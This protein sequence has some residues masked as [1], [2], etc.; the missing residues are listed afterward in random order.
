MAEK[1]TAVVFGSTGL[2]GEE[3]ISV[4]LANNDYEKVIAVTRKPLP[5][6]D[7]KL[8]EVQ[9]ADFSQLIQLGEKLK[10]S[11]FY[12]CIG[13]T[14][15]VAGSKEAFRKVDLDIPQEIAR[16]A[17]ALSIPALVVI[18][19]IG[20]SFESSNFYLKTKGEM[21]KSVR[22][23]YSGNLKIVRPS[24]LMG[25]RTEFRFGEKLGIGFMRIFGWLF[26]GPLKKYRGINAHDVALAMVKLASLPS[27][28]VV[29]ESDE[30][31]K[32]WNP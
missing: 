2:V 29:F 31:R 25:K 11:G 22:E 6:R 28:R 23:I 18:S 14:I 24:F 7:S 20:A 21:E 1:F 32:I 9:L 15:A 4:L 12:C 17:E 13:T 16:L 10:A 5:I 27:D 19:S 26:V 8:V 30:L 3:L